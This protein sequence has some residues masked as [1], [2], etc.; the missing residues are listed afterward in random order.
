VRKNL[1]LLFVH[2]MLRMKA[3]ICMFSLACSTNLTDLPHNV[4]RKAGENKRRMDTDDTLQLF[5]LLD[6]NKATLPLFAATNLSLLP[7]PVNSTRSEISFLMQDV[8]DLHEKLTSVQ[9]KLDNLC[10]VFVPSTVQCSTS[11][12][13]S[14]TVAKRIGDSNSESAAPLTFTAYG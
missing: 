10:S 6:V 7:S 12:G 13:S 9:S 1:V 8:H 4:T 5:A 3:K 14:S 2:F 11:A